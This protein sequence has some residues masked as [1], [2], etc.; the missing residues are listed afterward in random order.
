MSELLHPDS[1]RVVGYGETHHVLFLFQGSMYIEE[2]AIPVPVWDLRLAL[3]LTQEAEARV[4]ARPY[5]FRF[6]TRVQ[7]SRVDESGVVFVGG[8]VRRYEEVPN[9]LA[10]RNRVLRQNMSANDHPVVCETLIKWPLPF[11]EEDY[12]IDFDTRAVVH[13]SDPELV[14][15]RAEERGRWARK[16][17][18]HCSVSG[19]LERLKE[20]GRRTPPSPIEGGLSSRAGR[21][22]SFVR[23]QLGAGG[24]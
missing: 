20:H 13:G 4:G 8:R 24:F 11:N 2:R 15:Y 10:G 19:G 12:L 9:A 6:S 14:A 23:R 7:G 16:E 3:D 17:Y 18:D 22:L 21:L 5:G 1:G